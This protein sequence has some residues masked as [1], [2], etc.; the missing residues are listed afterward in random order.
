MSKSY[1]M[2]CRKANGEEV[3]LTQLMLDRHVIDIQ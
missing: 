3:G 1:A 2:V